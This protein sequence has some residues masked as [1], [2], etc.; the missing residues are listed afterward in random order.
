[1]RSLAS[2]TRS[3]D[4]AASLLALHVSRASL[5]ADVARLERS[6]RLVQQQRD[7]A[8]L[9]RRTLARLEAVDGSDPAAREALAVRVHEWAAAE[10]V[11]ARHVRR[12]TRELRAAHH[13]LRAMELAEA[14]ASAMVAAEEYCIEE[15]EEWGEAEADSPG[16]D[17]ARRDAGE[18][19]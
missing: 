5:L 4:S 14:A 1:M 7:E 13:A 16:D 19:D 9:D 17:R 3:E 2:T 11:L 8:D 10:Q 12:V 6:L 18:E 15:G